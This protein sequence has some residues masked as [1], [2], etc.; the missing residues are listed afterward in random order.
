M[1]IDLMHDGVSAFLVACSRR[2]G[3]VADCIQTVMEFVHRR[4]VGGLPRTVSLSCWVI[5]RWMN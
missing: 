4:L 1:D 2:E 3:R 5:L